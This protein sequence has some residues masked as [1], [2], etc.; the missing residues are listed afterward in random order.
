MI[1]L[2]DM[3]PAWGRPTGA[4]QRRL[5]LRQEHLAEII[6]LAKNLDDPIQ[7]HR[8]RCRAAYLNKPFSYNPLIAR[9]LPIRVIVTFLTTQEV[10]AQAPRMVSTPPPPSSRLATSFPVMMSSPLPV[11]TFSTA[12]TVSTKPSGLAPGKSAVR[13]A[14]FTTTGL[15]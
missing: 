8:L 12:V 2:V 13:A 5:P 10:V 3:R 9:K 4:Q 1:S 14:R 15:L 7:H 6:D 11:R